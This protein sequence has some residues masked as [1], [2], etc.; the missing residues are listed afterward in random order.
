ML[1][2]TGSFV[3]A[4]SEAQRTTKSTRRLIRCGPTDGHFE[5]PVTLKREACDEIGILNFAFGDGQNNSFKSPDHRITHSYFHT[6][7]E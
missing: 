2:M 4:H 3:L 1:K 5:H 6:T 7:P